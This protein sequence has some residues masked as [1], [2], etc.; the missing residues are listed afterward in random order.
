MNEETAGWLAVLMVTVGSLTWAVSLVL[1]E[2]IK[3]SKGKRRN[4]VAAKRRQQEKATTGVRGGYRKWAIASSVVV[5]LFGIGAVLI[6][7][8]AYHAMGDSRPM[9]A[10]KCAYLL[11]WLV[12][13]YVGVRLWQRYRVASKND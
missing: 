1:R 7:V 3:A 9:S 12:W 10:R 5:V 2:D 4:P 8:D 13:V 6:L 11:V